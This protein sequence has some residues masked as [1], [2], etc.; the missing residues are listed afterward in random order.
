MRAIRRDLAIWGALA[1][2]LIAAVWGSFLVTSR[3]V[4]EL[5]RQDAQT[6]GEAW[7]RYLAANVKDLG[8]IVAGERPSD[9]S[10]AFFEKAERV[11]DVFLYK[12][13]APSGTLRLS[14]HEPDEI[15]PHAE[16]IVAHNPEASAA[17]LAGHTVVE[18]K[19]GEHEDEEEEEEEAGIGD[20]PDFYSE[21]YVPVKIG[22]RVVGIM[23]AY[24][25]QSAK[26]TAFHARIG[27]LAAS[28][29]AIIAVAFAL[30]ACGFTWRTR[31]KRAAELRAEFLAKHDPLTEILNRAQFMRFLD[32]AIRFGGPIA[33]HVIDIV[34]FKDVN[35]AEGPATGDEIL[36]QIA[37]RLQTL[38]GRSDLVARLG[39][40]EFA[41][42]EVLKSAGQATRTARHVLGAL[43]EPFRV[44]GRELAVS[45]CLGSAVTPAHGRDAAG[46]LRNVE[47]AVNHSSNEGPGTRSLFRPEMDAELHTR[48]Q[49]EAMLRDALANDGFELQYQPIA[50]SRDFGLA[51]FEALL[52]LPKPDGTYIPPTT[53]VPLAE[54][55][56][57][58]S[59]I[60]LWVL[61]TACNVAVEWPRQLTV[62]VNL[63]PRQFEDGF[64]AGHVARALEASGLDPRRLEL[65]IT[66][67]LLL[68]D[69]D[70]VMQQL[71]DLKALGVGIAMDDFGT[72]YSS[73]NYLWRFPFGKLKIDQ[74]FVRALGGDDPHVSSVV[75]AI[76]ALGQSLGMTI[77]AEGVETEAQALFLRRAGCDLL[78]GFY[79]GRP[80]PQG[81]LAGA[82]LK[83]FR[84]KVPAEPQ[85][86]RVTAR[87]AVP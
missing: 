17:V 44:D 24:V 53:F 25:D 23:E 43:S 37:R 33:V 47:I 73:L 4:N 52:R 59:E 5:L 80:L 3:A 70:S 66:E 13:Y 61:R 19:D 20:F 82:I 42:A 12:V 7:A 72:G 85:A 8:A 29:A 36:K 76:V 28:L 87:T 21:A 84:A 18:V 41:I 35:D 11:G 31:Q 51:G 63:S 14:S 48:R 75:Q 40:D 56:G 81:R 86:P 49:L 16:S 55:L 57:L 15:D 54:R 32:E 50:R 1:A 67:G 78:Q 38:S 69:A 65:E 74:S 34:R 39:G 27:G 6:E 2:L 60:G 30:P 77:T 22:G 45:F 10:M 26:R 62:S 46:L 68:S 64:L 71:R 58:I 9:A 83:D 79:L